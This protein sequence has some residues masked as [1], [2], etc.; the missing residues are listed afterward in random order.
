MD[1]LA[2]QV[3]R[4]DPRF[5]ENRDENLKAIETLNGHLAKS[6]A[7]GGQKYVDR[8]RARGKLL[9]RERVDLLLDRDSPFLEIQPLAGLHEAGVPGG[10]TIV[11]LGWIERTLCLI[12]AS[13]A[14]V[15]GGAIGPVGL[16]KSLR[17]AT[18]ASE[19]HLP[20]VHC[21]ESAGADLPRQVEIFVPGGQAFRQI[22]ERSKQRLSTISLVFG[23]CTAG[24]AYVPG[25][26]DYTV[27]VDDAAYMY[28]AG[29]PLVK[30]AT[31]EE[32]DDETLGGARLH[33]ERSGVADFLAANETECIG[34]G[35]QLVARLGQQQPVCRQDGIA[36]PLYP[37]ED[38]LG[39]AETDL[40]RPFDCREVIARIVDGSR[41]FE[42]KPLYGPTLVTG[43]AELA[44]YRLGILANN[45]VLYGESA[46]KGAQFI[47]LCNQQNTPLLF[48]QNIT[49]FIVGQAAEAAGIIRS[50]AKMIN[51]V[52]NSTVPAIT[53]MIGGSYGAGNYAMCG[54][55]Y[56]PRLL[57]AW[58]NHKIG[59]MGAE[60]LAGV[61]ELVK[62]QAAQRSGKPVDEQQLATMKQ[63]LV[64]KIEHDSTCWAATG[65]GYDDGVI[66]PR[67]TRTVLALALAAVHRSPV[68]GTTRWGVFRH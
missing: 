44:G 48:L 7:G 32:V 34:I 36:P 41:F 4:R 62:R 43:F 68:R 58:P 14:T 26:S 61:L 35:R 39:I 22:T 12:T 60:Q 20:V 24:G 21:I 2:T 31:G 10:G 38:L 65:R 37:A 17:A 3:D 50:G 9:P 64:G 11:G 29:P 33:A 56:A 49:G 40:R 63:M 27:V 66:D 16:Q 42:F 23:S 46:E 67:D 51:A 25:M 19:N 52:T 55:A 54:R 47:M 28:L 18:I 15:Q 59:V 1:V 13:E 5:V 45:G 53:L 8:H 6:Y 57:F 30:M